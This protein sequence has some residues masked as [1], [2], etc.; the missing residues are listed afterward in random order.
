MADDT[1]QRNLNSITTSPELSAL[2][3][4]EFPQETGGT[5]TRARF[6][7]ISA[8]IKSGAITPEDAVK[9]AND[10]FLQTG[11]KFTF[12]TVKDRQA[13]YDADE[14]ERKDFETYRQPFLFPD[15]SPNSDFYLGP[16]LN[17]IGAKSGQGKTT[18]LANILAG[19][20]NYKPDTTAVVILNEEK[21]GTLLQRTACVLLGKSFAKFFHKGMFSREED[22]VRNLARELVNRIVVVDSEPYDANC[23]EDIKTIVT[24]APS[25]G[26]AL[27]MLD[28]FQN[29]NYSRENPAMESWKVLKDLG[30]FFK[31]YG[32]R[33]KVPIGA[34][35][36]LRNESDSKEFKDR[37]E[38]D[39][40]VF[41][42]S[43]N[44]VEIKPDKETGM[45]E[46]IV[47]K[48][49]F[50]YEQHYKVVLKYEGGRYLKQDV[51]GL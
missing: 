37:V 18:A 26:A 5:L 17:L 20:I 31:E 32:R 33:Q 3:T 49:R 21:G 51:V 23:L 43:A 40:H 30:S 48:Q 6:T 50:A 13:R 10:H 29:V 22:E 36:Q 8:E 24:G 38:N 16:G 28:Y 12:P 2:T 47:W 1:S 39:K 44:S 19:F 35:V 15:F 46:F 42:H 41:N 4:G 9:R 34:F 45:T 7:S 25:A 14:A 27:V 11:R